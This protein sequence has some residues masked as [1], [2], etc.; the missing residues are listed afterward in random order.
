[1]NEPYDVW[2][3]IS[4]INDP[5]LTGPVTRLSLSLSLI[6]PPNSD[7]DH[8]CLCYEDIEPNLWRLPSEEPS[9]LPSEEPRRL[10]SEEPR[11]SLSLSHIYPPIEP[12][13]EIEPDKRTVKRSRQSSGIRPNM[14]YIYIYI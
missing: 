2:N 10:P 12:Y 4:F 6:P 13:Q 9:R 1:M 11:R 14:R 7:T 5:L 8:Q 3:G